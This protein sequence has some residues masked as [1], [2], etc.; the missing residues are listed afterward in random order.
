MGTSTNA[1]STS[2]S[3]KRKT[4]SAQPVMI[5]VKSTDETSGPIGYSK[6]IEIET[7]QPHRS[8]DISPSRSPRY[9]RSPSL[10][11]STPEHSDEEN[12][13]DEQ[14]DGEESGNPI[15]TSDTLINKTNDLPSSEASVNRPDTLQAVDKSA[16]QFRKNLLNEVIRV[17]DDKADTIK[18]ITSIYT[19]E[20]T[21]ELSD[22]LRSIKK[23]T[24]HIDKM[25]NELNKSLG[26]VADTSETCYNEAQSLNDNLRTVIG[27]VK[28]TERLFHKSAEETYNLMKKANDNANKLSKLQESINRI[29]NAMPLATTITHILNSLDAIQ[30]TMATG[31]PLSLDTLHHSAHRAPAPIN[32]AIQLK[33]TLCGGPHWIIKCDEYL[34]SQE[35]KDRA[36]AINVCT[37][38][39]RDFTP[40][41][42]GKHLLC[43]R[44][45]TPCTHCAKSKTRDRD[46]ILHHPAF[47][48]LL[49]QERMERLEQERVHERPRKR[50]NSESGYPE[51]DQA[52]REPLQPPVFEARPSRQPY[53]GRH[54]RGSRGSRGFHRGQRPTA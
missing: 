47:C 43:K 27:D 51:Q 15:S 17:V 42:S 39:G 41:P 37:H 38:C 8:P 48:S 12:N 21:K 32:R 9:S 29:E 28:A 13:D 10:I 49:S 36:T 50:S 30:N 31:N 54:P 52:K 26:T 7:E 20:L 2:S 3:S 19:P 45:D 16:A 46:E 14:E 4:K 18:R 35:R 6:E 11:N 34:T 23:S 40:D 53:R 22:T 1:T 33:C 5:P 25:Q 24:S 44:L